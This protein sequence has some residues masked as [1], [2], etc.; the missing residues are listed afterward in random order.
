MRTLFAFIKKEW[1]EQVRS[2]KFL[3]LLIVFGLFGIMNPAIAKLTPWL[4]EMFSDALAESGMILGEVQVDAMTSWVQFFKNIPM[5]LIVFVLLQGGIFTKE[6]QSGTLILALTKGLKRRTVVLAKMTVLSVL[7]SLYYWLSLGITYVYNAYF[8]DNSIAKNLGFSALC[9][10]VFGLWVVAL[11]VFF[12]TL[13]KSNSGVLLGVGAM[14]MI[15]YFISLLPKVG[16]YMPTLLMDGNSLIYA[17]KEP[18]YYMTAFM[19]VVVTAI[20]GI[21]VSIPILNKKSI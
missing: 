7:W 9:W 2:G 16:K 1:M 11:M 21:V 6:Y 12:S 19:I 8:W 5:G 4:M 20:A 10:W 18:D 13:T 17:M 14:V 3:I 15:P